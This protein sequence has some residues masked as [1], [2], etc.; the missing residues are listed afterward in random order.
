[1]IASETPLRA[2]GLA[3]LE[4]LHGGHAGAAMVAEMR[5]I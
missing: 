5:D 4:Q 3:L 1:M 2:R